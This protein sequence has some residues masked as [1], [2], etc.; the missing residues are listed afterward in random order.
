MRR[1]SVHDRASAV[2]GDR[3]RPLHERLEALEDVMES[4]VG[5]TPLVRA[6]GLERKFGLSQ[7]YLKVDGDNPTGTHKDRIAFAQVVDALRRGYESLV[8]ATCG[9]YGVAMA[10]ACQVAKLRCVAVVPTTYHAPRIQQIVEL[11]ADVVRAGDSYEDAVDHARKLAQP[12]VLYDANPGGTNESIQLG[13]YREI[14][15]EVYDELRDAP[16]AIAVPVSNG[17]TLAGVYRGFVSLHRRGRTSRMPRMIAGSAWRKN[18][19]V[20][21]VR[22]GLDWV[23]D[24]APASIRETDVNE[25]LVNWHAIDGE[26]ALA[27]IRDTGGDAHD[28]TDKQMRELARLIRAEQGMNVLPASTAGL[29]A[30]LRLHA[31][32]ELPP[33]RYVAVLTGRTT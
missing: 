2:A 3:A 17:T 9:N 11:G 29:G 33:D 26:A 10:Y 27:A 4:E 20:Q 7:I 32:A 22:R 23:P 15:F 18:P 12:D 13:A 16:A 31:A 1:D 24:L 19:I 28:V 21:A 5:D 6:R 30:L 8:F 25:P 14:A